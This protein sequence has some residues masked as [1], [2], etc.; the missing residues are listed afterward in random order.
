[1]TPRPVGI[2]HWQSIF[3]VFWWPESEILHGSWNSWLVNIGLS[4]RIFS[5]FCRPERAIYPAS[6]NPTIE[7]P[8]FTLTTARHFGNMK[9]YKRASDQRYSAFVTL[10]FNILKAENCLSSSVRK[11]R[12]KVMWLPVDLFLHFDVLK[13]PFCLVLSTRVQRLSLKHLYHFGVLKMRL[14]KYLETLDLEVSSIH[15]DSI[16]SFGE[17]KWESSKVIGMLFVKYTVFRWGP[18]RHYCGLKKRLFPCRNVHHLRQL[19]SW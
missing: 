13:M 15:K 3:S 10:I 16:R 18:V 9:R 1:M 7:T 8:F 19:A 6:L 11:L 12:L 14:L 17:I 2:K 5:S 4:L